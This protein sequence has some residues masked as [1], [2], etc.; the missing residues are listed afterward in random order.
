MGID[1]Q[2]FFLTS[3]SILSVC[4]SCHDGR[5]IDEFKDVD[6]N[7]WESRDTVSFDLP[8]I[9]R[10]ADV[11]AEIGIRL[12]DAYTFKD[13]YVTATLLCDD[14][15]LSYDTV[16]VGIYDAKGNCKGQGFPYITVTKEAPTVHVDSGRTYTYK[17]CHIMNPD[18]IKGICGIGL[19]LDAQ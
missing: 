18:T 13:L 16:R 19:K 17:I 2:V 7:G 11:K 6:I 14:K 9:T 4:A 12:S 15:E 5:V 3:L 10:G 8:K 1:K